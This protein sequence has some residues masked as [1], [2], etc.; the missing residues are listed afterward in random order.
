MRPDVVF[1][2]IHTTC[3]P[4]P[5]SNRHKYKYRKMLVTFCSGNKINTI[6][7][8]KD[9]LFLAGIKAGQIPSDKSEGLLVSII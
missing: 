1:S 5:F 8:A 3:Y 2:Q 4:G 7:A 9:Q 6:N